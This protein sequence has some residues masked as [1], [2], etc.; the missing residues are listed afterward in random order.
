M[1]KLM[2]THCVLCISDRMPMNPKQQK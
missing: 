2:T 1:H